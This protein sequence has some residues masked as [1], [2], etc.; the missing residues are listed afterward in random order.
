MEG[1][2]GYEL[3]PSVLSNEEKEEIKE[4]VN[5]FKQHADLVRE[6]RYYRL[7]NPFDDTY[8]AWQFVSEDKTEVLMSVVVLE[9]HKIKEV[10]YVN[11]Y[12]DITEAKIS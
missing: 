11:T 1:T 6:G 5:R 4:Q 2:F 9:I 3:N 12:T 8:T 7:S 10:N